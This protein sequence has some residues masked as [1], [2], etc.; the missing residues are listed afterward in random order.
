MGKVLDK[1]LDEVVSE[2]GPQVIDKNQPIKLAEFDVRTQES[3]QRPGLKARL[4]CSSIRPNVIL[5]RLNK[6]YIDS[7]TIGRHSNGVIALFLILVFAH[8]LPAPKAQSC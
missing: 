7:G 6:V 8:E 4:F 2:V 5:S 3:G 1:A